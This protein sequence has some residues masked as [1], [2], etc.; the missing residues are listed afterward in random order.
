MSERL[1]V[2]GLV[3]SI[4]SIGGAERVAASLARELDPQRFD[5]LLCVTRRATA[6]TL[7]AELRAAGVTLVELERRIMLDMPAWRR[8]VR[9]LRRE[10]VDVLHAHMFGSNVWGTVLG[11]VAGVPVVIAHEHGWSYRGRPLRRLIDREVVA[12]GADAYLAVSE[13][14]RRQMTHVERIPAERIHVVPNG[15]PPL[16]RA[17]HDVRAELGIPA[18]ASV[19]GTVCELRPEKAL[20]VLVDAAAQ[21]PDVHVLI[22]GDGPEEAKLRARIRGA[23]VGERVRL[24]GRR[25]DVA[26]VLAALDVAACCSDF[27]AA[28]LS[29]MEYMAAALPVVA[30]RVGGL[31]DLVRD[32]ETGVLVDP[33]N[34]GALAAAVEALLESPEQRRRLGAAGRERQ[35][36]EYDFARFVGRMEE[37]YV[38]LRSRARHPSNE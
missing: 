10:R 13:Y 11:R 37:L 12:R 31:P 32:G 17:G 24:L 34:P 20:E 8:L 23:G 35:R 3:D 25:N 14:D 38:E 2:L 9:L 27:E 26:D 4:S 19:I 30:T 29:V 15:I 28:P 7:E 6:P 21:L 36:A 22:V 33:R 5:R 16:V 1:R 18:G